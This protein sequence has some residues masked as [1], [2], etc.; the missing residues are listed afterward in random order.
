[1]ICDMGENLL[2][3]QTAPYFCVACWL[4]PVVK[5]CHWQLA[6]CTRRV[7]K[8]FTGYQ[9]SRFNI[10]VRFW[11]PFPRREIVTN[12]NYYLTGRINTRNLNCENG[13][14]I[15]ETFLFMLF[16]IL[17]LW[18]KY[19]YYCMGRRNWTNYSQIHK[20][21]ILLILVNVNI[22]HTHC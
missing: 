7:M 11:M 15:L 13:R 8:Y 20:I 21:Q 4:I 18:G 10:E 5:P 9:L 6:W 3:D 1:M 19:F 22:S 14:C 2:V 12:A 16:L 17:L